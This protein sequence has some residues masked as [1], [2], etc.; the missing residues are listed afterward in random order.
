MKLNSYTISQLTEMLGD[1]T[2]EEYIKIKN[3]IKEDSRK[4][5]K[6]LVE[7]TEKRFLNLE[8]LKME[9]EARKKFELELMEQNYKYIAGVDEVGRGPLAG[10]V[11]AAA[12]ILDL[13]EDIYGIKDSKKLSEKQRNKLSLKIREKCL[14]YSIAFASREE[15]DNYNILN[16]TKL[17]MKRAIEGLKIIPDYILVDAI[18]ING[19]EIPQKPIIKG[20]DLSIS[21]GAASI[22]AKVERDNY[23]DQMSSIY[24]G[25]FFDS[26]KGYGTKEHTDAIKK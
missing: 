14:A 15:I 11:Y 8:K 7:R 1:C 22:I 24:P 25:Y 13:S 18:T 26:N 12:V 2:Y 9:Y 6:N 5:V 19:V 17:A 21:I 4:N 3:I 16:A 10:S 23:M 20:D